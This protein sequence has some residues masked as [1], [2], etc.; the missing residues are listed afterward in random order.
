MMV[1]SSPMLLLDSEVGSSA[2]LPC[3]WTWTTLGKIRLDL[4]KSLLPGKTPQQSFELYSVPAHEGGV[5]ELKRGEEIGSNKRTVAEGTV[6]ICK[7]NPRI[8][9]TWVVGKHSSFPKIASTEWIPF[10]PVEGVYPKYLSAFGSTNAFRNHLASNVSGVGGSL[11]RVRPTV[12]DNYP[13]PLPPLPEQHRIVEKI[14]ALFSELDKGI[15]QLETA[16]EQLKVYRQSVLK[17]AFEG[18]LT[19]EWRTMQNEKLKINN[20]QELLA[21]IKEERE[22]QAKASG[23]PPNKRRAGKLKPIAP[24]TEKE[25][26]EL[27]E[28]P[29]GWGWVKF[30]ALVENFDGRRVPLS[31]KQRAT[32]KGDF[33]YYGA[34]DIIDHVKE[35]LFDGEFL[36]IGE[37]GANLL[38]K[39]RDLA[40]VVT[41]KFWVNN[42]AHVCQ[43]VQ[44]VDITYLE[45]QFNSLNLQAFVTGTAQPKLTQANLDKIPIAVCQNGEQHQIVQ[46]IETRLSVCDKLEETITA[47]LQQSEA[48]RQSILKKAFEGKLVPQDPNDPP[49]SE[50]VQRIKE[51]KANREADKVSGKKKGLRRTSSPAN[52][53]V[54]RVKRKTAL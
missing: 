21:Q 36:L 18:K 27:P 44:F 43:P 23:N 52:E 3:G 47:G 34:C 7:I 29:E 11:M 25:F 14:E 50:L 37:D 41:G 4:S 51:E 49:A 38:S 24:L 30:G 26:A 54:K 8:N 46:E 5:P 17:W 31:A 1:S 45:A 39:S 32:F 10:F 16:Q 53:L 15:E 20:G 48:L 28:L 13:F 12:L 22:N 33:P 2:P 42:H 35:Y 9:R 19:A 6:L 40:F